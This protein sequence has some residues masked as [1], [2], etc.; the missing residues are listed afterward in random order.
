MLSVEEVYTYFTSDFERSCVPSYYVSSLRKML[1]S[2]AGYYDGCSWWLRST[3]SN[4]CRAAYVTGDGEVSELG[5]ENN[6][7]VGVRPALWIS[8]EP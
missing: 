6:Q 1:G 2:R 8:I 3:G 5:C 4:Q 7:Y